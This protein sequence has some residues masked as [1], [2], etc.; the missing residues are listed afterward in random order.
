[1]IKKK[2]RYCSPDLEVLSTGFMDLLCQSPQSGEDINN[3]GNWSGY[4]GWN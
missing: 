4:D 2:E 1:M 3:P